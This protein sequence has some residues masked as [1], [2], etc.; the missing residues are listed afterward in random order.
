MQ[1]WGWEHWGSGR[2]RTWGRPMWH[3]GHSQ[4]GLCSTARQMALA[5]HAA[6][7]LHGSTHRPFR[8]AAL[9]GQSKSATH[10]PSEEA[11][12]V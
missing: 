11:E 6:R 7:R 10:F 1:C 12:V 9:G 3:C 4:R 2:Q 8:Q 5:P